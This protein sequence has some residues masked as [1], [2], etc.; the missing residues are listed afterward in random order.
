MVESLLGLSELLQQSTQDPYELDEDMKRRLRRVVVEG[1]PEE[2]LLVIL[3][4]EGVTEDQLRRF[5]LYQERIDRVIAEIMA[6]EEPKPIESIVKG[7]RGLRRGKTNGRFLLQGGF[8]TVE[9][10]LTASLD[11]ILAVPEIGPASA[12]SIWHELRWAGYNPEWDWPRPPGWE[13]K[14]K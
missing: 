12:R 10:V 8:N 1:T 2:R 9:D 4:R 11:E 3:K 6:D 5:L 14:T 13:E 7:C